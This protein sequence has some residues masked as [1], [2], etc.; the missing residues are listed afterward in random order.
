MAMYK[1]TRHFAHQKRLGR[2]RTSLIILSLIGVGFVAITV[3]EVTVP[4]QHALAVPAVQSLEATAT[5][6]RMVP[7][8]QLSTDDYLSRNLNDKIS[9]PPSAPHECRPDE[10]IVNDCTFN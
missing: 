10:G 2:F 5:N 6:T 4:Q 7:D 1:G 8:G 9:T 3:A